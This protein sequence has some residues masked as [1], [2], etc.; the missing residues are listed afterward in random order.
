MIEKDI[1]TLRIGIKVDI[2]NKE[3]RMVTFKIEKDKLLI[4]PKRGGK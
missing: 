2:I 4:E 3:N 1:R